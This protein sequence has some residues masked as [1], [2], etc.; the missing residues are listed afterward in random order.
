MK[1]MHGT[2]SHSQPRGNEDG[3]EIPVWGVSK[4]KFGCDP[5]EEG[6]KENCSICW[7]PLL[8]LQGLLSILEA[9][10]RKAFSSLRGPVELRLGGIDCRTREQKLQQ[11]EQQQQKEMG[12]VGRSSTHQL[13]LL[14]GAS[15]VLCVTLVNG[16]CFPAVFNFGDSQS[17][18]GGIHAAFPSFTPAEYSPYGNTY[19]QQPQFRYSDGRL[20]I[21]FITTGMGLP[22][23]DPYLQSVT[24][25][26]YHGAN[27]ATAG[28]TIE[29]VTYLSPFYFNIQILQFMEFQKNVIAMRNPKAG[30]LG[31]TSTTI[32]SAANTYAEKVHRLPLPEFFNQALYMFCIGGNDFTYYYNKG[33]SPT[34]LEEYLPQIVDGLVQGIK[35]LY[36]AGG[37]NFLVWD[38]EPHGCLPYMLTLIQHTKEDLD[39]R[40]CLPPYN[41]VAEKYNDLM[42]QTLTSLKSELQDS[43]IVIFSTYQLRSDLIRDKEKFGFK[44]MNKACCGVPNE[45]HFDLRVAC[46]MSQVIN[47]ETV[48]STT[49]EEPSE[50]II[51]DG[52]HT[53][54]AAN[55][56][57]AK[58]FFSGKYF[59]PRFDKLMSCN[60]APVT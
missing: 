23:L 43:V 2:G 18:T 55:K 37:R 13:L 49:C 1:E 50:Y 12:S 45:Y 47:N 24:S 31:R 33:K 19:F 16:S 15:L 48:A 46:G 8:W 7:G 54:E 17:D 30:N 21:D 59:Y 57:I 11:R 20:L 41:K 3:N 29:A 6:R 10:S 34:E 56:Y 52:V 22:F 9:G 26:F 25:D 27:F 36:Y 28:A 4:A 38:M 40:G 14:W 58:Q 35:R 60:I 42:N 53:T 39:E 5:P 44:V 32:K 51:W